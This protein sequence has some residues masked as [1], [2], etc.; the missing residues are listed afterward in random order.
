MSKQV[1]VY[2]I[3]Q[4]HEMIDPIIPLMNIDEMG[5]LALVAQ[6]ILDRYKREKYPNYDWSKDGDSD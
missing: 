3:R 2:Q 5:T 1:D 6:S 4:V